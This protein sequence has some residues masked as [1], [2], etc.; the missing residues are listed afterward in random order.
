MRS[1]PLG[2]MSRAGGGCL[3]SWAE[4]GR[5]GQGVHTLSPGGAVWTSGLAF[6]VVLEVSVPQWVRGTPHQLRQSIRAS[7]R[8]GRASPST[9]LLHELLPGR[10]SAAAGLAPNNGKNLHADARGE[11]LAPCPPTIS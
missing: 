6:Q 2:H 1:V 10:L 3:G 9:S 8:P 11:A 7:G 4:L 5:V